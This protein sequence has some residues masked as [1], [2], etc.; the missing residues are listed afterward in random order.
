MVPAAK[1]IASCTV[2]AR[3]GLRA[4]VG[5]GRPHAAH[6]PVV[7]GSA[8]A[9]RWL[10]RSRRGCARRTRTSSVGSQARTKCAPGTHET[11]QNLGGYGR[12]GRGTGGG[13]KWQV[14][15]EV[16]RADGSVR[17]HE[18][19][20]GTPEFPAFPGVEAA[21]R[22]LA[23]WFCGFSAALLGG[24]HATGQTP[25]ITTPRQPAAWESAPGCTP[26]PSG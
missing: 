22:G 16:T 23:H 11:V 17:V 2:S 12:P 15:M 1:I 21:G 26:R 5:T 19:G 18:I 3:P 14:V 24:N 13:M 4:A 6:A 10:P 20:G 8:S 25:G 7:P 9:S